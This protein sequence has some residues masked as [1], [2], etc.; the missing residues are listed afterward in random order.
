MATSIS[1][2]LKKTNYSSGIEFKKKKKRE[3]VFK[4]SQYSTD[5]YINLLKCTISNYPY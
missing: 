2:Q 4:G 1:S 5:R 3:I